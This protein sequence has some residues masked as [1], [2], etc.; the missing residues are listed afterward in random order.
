V[1]VLATP[2]CPAAALLCYCCLVS[3]WAA[4]DALLMRTFPILS[5]AWSPQFDVNN[6]ISA[7]QANVFLVSMALAP[8]S[9]AVKLRQH[10]AQVG[11]AALDVNKL[12]SMTSI[13]K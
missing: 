9:F 5:G 8:S 13:S 1:D 7:V 6:V 11:H 2:Y 12:I 3:G 10:P 4:A